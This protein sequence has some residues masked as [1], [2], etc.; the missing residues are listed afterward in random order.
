MSHPQVLAGEG[1]EARNVVAL[2]LGVA[3]TLQVSEHGSLTPLGTIEAG[4]QRQVLPLQ[5]N[6]V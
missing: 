6:V 3:V 5:A 4:G 2:V 1:S